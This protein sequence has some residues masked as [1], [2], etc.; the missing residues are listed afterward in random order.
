C[1]QC[2]LI[3]RGHAARLLDLYISRAPGTVNIK[4]HVHPIGLVNVG[5][6]FVFEPVLRYF[7]LPDPHIPGIRGSEI[8]ASTLEAE[9]TF[10]ARSAEGAIRAT[11]RT[12]LP[13]GHLIGFFGRRLRG[14]L[15][16]GGG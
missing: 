9:A 3:E 6:D 4:L 1:A 5:I 10:G 2:R 12:A 14:F 16:A 11:N 13:K 15:M 8:S 7:L